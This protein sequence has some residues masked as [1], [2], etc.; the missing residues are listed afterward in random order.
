MYNLYDMFMYIYIY[1]HIYIY[2]YTQPTSRAHPPPHPCFVLAA[3]IPREPQSVRGEGATP[4]PI[5]WAG[6]L[7][8]GYGIVPSITCLAK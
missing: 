4:W 2:I 6:G 8:N 3:T 1:I 7:P 5:W